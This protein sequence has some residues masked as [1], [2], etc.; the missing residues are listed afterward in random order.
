MTLSTYTKVY[1]NSKKQANVLVCGSIDF[2]NHIS[3]NAYA[4]ADILK[5]AF[6]LMGNVNVVTGIDYKVIEDTTITVSQKAFRANV[7]RL[8]V[9]IP[10]IIA[11]IGIFVYIK[12]KKA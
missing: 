7:I 8:S 3:N 1:N 10:L 5:S 9:I 6:A 12:R 11:A 4:N 2:L